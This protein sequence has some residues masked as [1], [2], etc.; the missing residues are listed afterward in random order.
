[1]LSRFGLRL[2]KAYPG[3]HFVPVVTILA[4]LRACFGGGNDQKQVG[5]AF[6]GALRGEAV[7]ESGGGFGRIG[8]LSFHQKFTRAR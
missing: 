8:V 7:G 3:M 4:L 5:A 2:L 6:R 1:M